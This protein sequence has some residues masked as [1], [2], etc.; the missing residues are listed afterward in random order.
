[1]KEHG[2]SRRSYSALFCPFFF[3]LFLVWLT[4]FAPANSLLGKADSQHFS[5]Q[6]TPGYN[7]NHYRAQF[8]T[9]TGVCDTSS[10]V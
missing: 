5:A 1:M 7:P 4:Y 2:V 6:Y 3:R 10:T 9:G 8:R